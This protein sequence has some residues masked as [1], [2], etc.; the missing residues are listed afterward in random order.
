[1]DR[2]VKIALG[3]GGAGCLGLIV[4]AVAAVSL[5]LLTGTRSTAN[6]NYDFNTNRSS[7]SST[8]RN[9]NTESTS[10]DNGSSS[11]NSS[12]SSSSSSMS[13]DARHRL[14]HAAS[15]T[16]NPE[17]IKRVGVK[18]GIL[19]DDNTATEDNLEFVTEHVGWVLR[20]SDFVQSI[21]T[22]AKARAYVEAHIND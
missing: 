18:I 4:V 8:A 20:N 14:F 11:S 16:G 6:R 10:N 9:A 3:C 12:S 1:M 7:R 13:E 19:N 2:N 5:Y 22:Q 21:N 15:A 17:T